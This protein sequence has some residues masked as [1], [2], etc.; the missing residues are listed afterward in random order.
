MRRQSRSLA[1]LAFDFFIHEHRVAQQWATVCDAVTNAI[2]RCDTRPV[3]VPLDLL[4][5]RSIHRRMINR[6]V[7]QWQGTSRLENS[8]L[9]GRT[10]GIDGEDAHVGAPSAPVSADVAAI[11][12]VHQIELPS[13][14]RR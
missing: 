11:G 6:R 14:A 13:F 8:E 5:G 7:D 3:Q 4:E 2:E 12:N 10:A 1:D 9:Q